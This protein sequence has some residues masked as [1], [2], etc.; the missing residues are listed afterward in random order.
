MLGEVLLAS[1]L[2]PEFA[3]LAPPLADADAVDFVVGV[4]SALGDALSECFALVAGLGLAEPPVLPQPV[5]RG[6][7]VAAA[8]AVTVALAPSPAEAEAATDCEVTMLG[9]TGALAAE[10]DGETVVDGLAGVDV[11]TGLLVCGEVLADAS[12]EEDVAAHGAPAEG[13]WLRAVV[14]PPL[15]LAAPATACPAEPCP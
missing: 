14:T 9:L 8:A 10:M 6:A 13:L 15:P 5:L 12:A 11:T 3:A 2:S 1:E 7:A 4:V